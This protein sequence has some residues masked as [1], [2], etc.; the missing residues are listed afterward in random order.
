[1]HDDPEQNPLS[2]EFMTKAHYYGKSLVPVSKTDEVLFKNE[3]NRCLRAIGFTD[4]YRVSRH[5]FLA[6]TDVIIPN[7]TSSKDYRAFYALIQ[8]MINSNKVLLCRYVYRNNANPKL[9]CLTPH[10]SKS[11]PVLYLNTLPT[12][13]D[14]RDYQFESLKEC[15]TQQEE[16]VSKFIDS[17]DLEEEEEEKLK[18]SATFNPS[19][20]YF[21]QC[22]E[23][24]ALNKDNNI[25]D[26]DDTI[27]DYLKP[28]KKLF[29]NNKY[30]SFIPKMF[31][32]K[33]RQ[34]EEKKKRVFW[35][36]M[37][38]SEIQDNTGISDRRLEEKLEKNKEEAKKIISMTRPIEDFKEMMN[39]KY[40]DLTESAMGQ[41][42]TIIVKFILESFKGS[43]YIKALD[44][45][46]ELR[47]ACIQEDEV[48][49]FN[50][51][52]EE[53]RQNFPKEKF[54]DLWRLISDNKITLISNGE[55]KNSS[56]TEKECKDWL[57][58]IMKKEVITST[59]NDIDNLI[60]DI[61]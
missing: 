43:Y 6:G 15:S 23:H 2:S 35:K 36:E 60:A 32:I 17:L 21:Y 7:P 13:E 51:F 54:V 33:E 29:E 53:F 39:Y 34:K 18:P 46:K 55:N 57:D 37:I 28:D 9:V 42:K 31:E 8:E 25:P 48:E 47:E 22:L 56:F 49:L 20:Q 38:N 61:D 1:M 12:V 19:L 40:E 30:V 3:E 44:C 41:M 45:L 26:L 59:F 4:N 24:K 5:H 27:E 10:I 50:S 14:I 58:N 11:G 52:M 16:V